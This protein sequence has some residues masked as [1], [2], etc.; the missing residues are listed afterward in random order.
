MC[1]VASKLSTLFCPSVDLLL[2]LIVSSQP[3]WFMYLVCI[4][5]RVKF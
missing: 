2:V 4:Y 3:L 5:N 1:H